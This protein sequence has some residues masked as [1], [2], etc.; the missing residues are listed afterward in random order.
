MSAIRIPDDHLDIL[1]IGTKTHAQIEAHIQGIGNYAFP[2]VDGAL[3]QILETNG[4]GVLL[5]VNKP[6]GFACGSLNSCNLTD[7]GTRA[8]SSLTG[9]GAGDH[10][11]KYTDTEAV[12]A[13]DAAEKFYELDEWNELSQMQYFSSST[14]PTFFILIRYTTGS[15]S[16]LE[17]VKAKVQ[18]SYGTTQT[19]G[20]RIKF[21]SYIHKGTDSEMNTGYLEMYKPKYFKYTEFGFYVSNSSGSINKELTVRYDYIDI[22]NNP[23]KDIKNH[24][25]AT[26]SGTPKIIELLVGSTSYYFKVYPTKT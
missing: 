6:A 8:H 21:P 16:T 19:T 23:I 12:A 22:H 15:L 13:C 10:H 20:S 14:V 1:N 24:V 17:M 11:V 5:W 26:L 7:I 18:T 25:D 9:I 3:N 4:A 2:A